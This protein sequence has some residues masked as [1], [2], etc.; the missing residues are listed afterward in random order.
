MLKG[1]IRIAEFEP[2]IFSVTVTCSFDMRGML[3]QGLNSIYC[4]LFSATHIMNIAD[5]LKSLKNLHK[6]QRVSSTVIQL[7]IS[8]ILKLRVRVN[9]TLVDLFERQQRIGIHLSEEK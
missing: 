1:R 4:L 2:S 3:G 9:H 6:C 7:L 8:L 5:S